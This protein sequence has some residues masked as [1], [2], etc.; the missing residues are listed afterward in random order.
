VI[1]S[2]T[3]PS[4]FPKPLK[5]GILRNG[6]ASIIISPSCNLPVRFVL[7]CAG[8]DLPSSRP[9]DAIYASRLRYGKKEAKANGKDKITK[10]QN[11]APCLT[12]SGGFLCRL[13]SS[14]IVYAVVF[15]KPL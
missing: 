10:Y 5:T 11:Y 3:I 8:E 1:I 7:I 14:Y 12:S 9:P 2:F 4:A 13:S 6:I 15:H